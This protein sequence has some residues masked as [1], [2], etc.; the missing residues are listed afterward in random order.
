MTTI[1]SKQRAHYVYRLPTYEPKLTALGA[2][3]KGQEARGSTPFPSSS[4]QKIAQTSSQ[5]KDAE[6]VFLFVVCFFACLTPHT[7]N[8]LLLP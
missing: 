6:V 3:M 4:S 1:R 7:A 8:A 2:E 5:M